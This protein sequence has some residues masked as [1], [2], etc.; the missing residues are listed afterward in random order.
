MRSALSSAAAS[1]SMSSTGPAARHTPSSASATKRASG[2][3]SANA[4]RAASS[5]KSTPGSFWV[6]RARARAPA[7]TVACVVRSP[8]PTSSASA[9]RT[10]GSSSVSSILI[11]RMV[12][13]TGER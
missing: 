2:S 7:G 11:S 10:S 4:S 9:R 3:S 13:G 1:P 5:P 8:E 12:G 6:I